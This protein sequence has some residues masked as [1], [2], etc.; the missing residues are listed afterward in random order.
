MQPLKTIFGPTISRILLCIA[1]FCTALAMATESLIEDE[2]A[3]DPNGLV[4]IENNAAD[5]QIPKAENID[6]GEPVLDQSNPAT[7]SELPPVSGYTGDLP[8]AKGIDLQEPIVDPD[9]AQSSDISAPYQVKTLAASSLII[10]GSEVQPGIATRLSWSPSQSYEGL[11]SPTPVL[12]AHGANPGPTLCLTAAIHGDELNGIEIV[13]RVLYNINVEKLWGTIIGVP[14]VNLQGFH[15]GS[16]Y[17]T[18]R[19]DLN[20]YFPGNP[21]GSAASRIAYSFFKEIIKHCDALV[22][23]HTGSFFRTNLPQL[24]ADLTNPSVVELSHGFGATVVLHSRGTPGTLRYAAVAAGIPAVTLEAGGP[25]QLQENA[26]EH[27]VKGI[28]TLLN[29]LGMYKKI[30]FWGDPEPVYYR[31]IWI[32]VNQTGILLSKVKLGERVTKGMLLGVVTDPITN[33]QSEIISPYNGRILGKAINQVVQPGF[34]AFRIG[35]Q[36]TEKNVMPLEETPADD[37]SVPVVPPLEAP[38]EDDPDLSKGGSVLPDQ[39][40]AKH[41][42]SE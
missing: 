36:Q 40:I 28:Q 37:G 41:A 20:R 16:R 27:G 17:L 13:R 21:K 42:D 25:M 7:S 35:I 39:Y 30:S 31:S 3:F 22:D 2:P 23:L 9:Q 26:V 15:R 19:R 33:I 10:L 6:L 34:A 18:D 24:R 29:R 14:I 8:K 5:Q 38:D 32:R 12:I 11:A 4:I 1:T